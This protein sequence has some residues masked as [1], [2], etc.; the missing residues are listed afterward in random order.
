MYTEQR[1][2]QAT[3][4]D[5]PLTCTHNAQCTACRPG[6]LHHRP[7]EP[8]WAIRPRGAWIAAQAHHMHIAPPAAPLHFT[9][10]RLSRDGPEGLVVLGSQPSP[11]LACCRLCPHAPWADRLECPWGR[12]G[13]SALKRLPFNGARGSYSLLKLVES[14]GNAPPQFKTYKAS[15]TR[16]SQQGSVVWSGLVASAVR[17]CVRR[18]PQGI[19][20][21]SRVPSR[22]GRLAPWNGGTR[23]T[24]KTA[25][26]RARAPCRCGV[27]VRHRSA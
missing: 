2:H 4:G 20:R 9:I 12:V 16:V 22:L 24:Q 14:L 10:G 17:A 3:P 19:G 25:P 13:G 7:I 15:V 27:R 11:V 21:R 8:R 26:R 5:T 1:S 18:S 23:G 6:P